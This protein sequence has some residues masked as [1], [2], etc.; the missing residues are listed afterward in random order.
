MI[1]FL[2]FWIRLDLGVKINPTS[3]ADVENAI[4]L[5]YIIRMKWHLYEGCTRDYNAVWSTQHIAK[6]LPIKLLHVFIWGWSLCAPRTASTSS[7]YTLCSID[8][9]AFEAL[10][11]KWMRFLVC[12]ART[13]NGS[14]FTELWSWLWQNANELVLS[15]IKTNF[16]T[17]VLKYLKQD[18]SLKKSLYSLFP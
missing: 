1:P 2:S 3:K 15:T 10:L 11:C 17:S 5:R 6:S 9:F 4:V 16:W 14:Y 7:D 12:H 13:Q 18:S 8:P